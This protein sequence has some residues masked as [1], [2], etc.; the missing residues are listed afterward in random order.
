MTS[1]EVDY[2]VTILGGCGRVGL[3]LGISLAECGLRVALVDTNAQAVTEVKAGRMPFREADAEGPLARCVTERRIRATEDPSVIATARSV[4]VVIGTPIDDHLN[5]S[6][7]TVLNVIADVRAHMRRGQLLVLRST[8]Y[9]GVTRLVEQLVEE[10][11]VDVAFCPERIAEGQSMVELRDLPQIVSART[12]EAM[13][14]ARELFSLLTDEIVELSPEE[15]ELAKLFTNAWRYIKFAAANQ[16]F[17]IANGYGLDFCR[18]RDALAYRY[19][20][21]ADM[22]K[23]GFAAGPCLLKDT[24]QL[25]AFNNN[26][27]TLGHVSMMINEG[28][29]LYVISEAEKWFDFSGATV[30][31]LGMAFKGGSD[32]IRDSLSYKLKRIL[33]LKA[34]DVLCTDPYVTV[35][36]TLSSLDEVLERASLL[37]IGA[38]HAEYVKL[39]SPAPI[40]DIWGVTGQGTRV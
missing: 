23:A 15:A 25:A 27:F 21:A 11:A 24:M 29:P 22:P 37:V 14:R 38:P 26:N 35:D 6:P 32:D 12:P 7:D 9:P 8:L 30:G 2:D 20:R 16:F 39:K 40:I 19:P 5:P 34:R 1:H 18:I 10:L 4:I 28:L 31:L 17:M 33:K 36:P 13:R 3:P